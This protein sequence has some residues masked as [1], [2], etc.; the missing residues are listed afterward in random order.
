MQV[1]GIRLNMQQPGEAA[2]YLQY[3]LHLDY[4]EWLW[5]S[6]RSYAVYFIS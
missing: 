6:R 5:P 2:R 4:I 1:R 3:P